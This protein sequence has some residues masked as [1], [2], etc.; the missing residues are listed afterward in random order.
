MKELDKLRVLL[1]HWI[2]HNKG[3]G[4]EFAQWSQQ[5]TASGSQEEIAGL[6][7]QAEEAL[8]V[9]EAAL[10]KAL[11][12]AGGPIEGAG[13]NHHHHHHNLPE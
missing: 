1:P 4:R 12:K 2:E 11:E 7:K 3:H 10:K 5:L 9:A 6:L 13:H 8:Q